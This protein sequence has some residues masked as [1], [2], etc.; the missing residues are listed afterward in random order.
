[1][2]NW[3][4]SSGVYTNMLR[5]PLFLVCSLAA[6]AQPSPRQDPLEAALQAVRQA[7]NTGHFE[8][9]VA[10]REQARALLP[11]APVDSPQ[12]AFWVQ[13]VAQLYRNSNWNSQA[14]AI[15]RDALDRTGP[16]GDSHPSRIAL[17][18]ALADSWRQDGNL[19]KTVGYLEQ[20]AAAQ[21]ATPAPSTPTPA[22]PA[23]IDNS[24]G[25]MP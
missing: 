12:F 3:T 11:R 19:L 9:A 4:R 13:Q 5:V 25:P 6:L 15:L 23:Y 7:R 20:A 17:L 24:A 18:N 22:C 16:L 2:R 8:E 21:S 10:A 14:R 1:L